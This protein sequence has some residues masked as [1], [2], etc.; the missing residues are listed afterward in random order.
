MDKKKVTNLLKKALLE[1]GDMVQKLYKF[2]LEKGIDYWYEGLKKDK[3]DYVF[4]VTENRGHVDMILISESKELLINEKARE[5]LKEL[6]PVYYH[7]TMSQLIP[8]MVEDF[9]AG[10]VSINGF[11]IVGKRTR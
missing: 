6:W 4:V 11:N 9:E 7:Q 3:N 1:D 5:K 8:G 10:E 2:E